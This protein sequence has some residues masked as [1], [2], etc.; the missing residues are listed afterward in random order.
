[1][2]FWKRFGALGTDFASKYQNNPFFRTETRIVAFHV[3]FA[4]FI[5]SALVA[6][7]INTS[8]FIGTTPT[9]STTTD[10]NA[11]VTTLIAAS[12]EQLEYRRIRNLTLVISAIVLATLI[13]S[14]VL[15]QISLKPAREALA[16]QKIFVS[17]IAHELRTPLSTIQT[18]T[19]VALFDTSLN[20]ALRETLENNVRDLK[21]ISEI[22]NNLL[23]L[24]V[25]LQ[26]ERI[27]FGKI[28]LAL[29]VHTALERL[30]SLSVTKQ[31]RLNAP[32]RGNFI[33]WGNGNALE[34]IVTNILK[35]ALTHTPSGGRV[36]IRLGRAEPAMVEL[37]IE[38]TG[39]GIAPADLAHI[40]EPFFRSDRSRSRARG[41]AGLGLTIVHELVKLHRGSIRVHSVLKQGTT[42]LVRIPTGA[43]QSDHTYP[44]SPLSNEI[45]VDYSEERG[46]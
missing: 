38:D 15:A 41:E 34:Q 28:D 36:T 25:S 8:Y 30:N 45:T 33:V 35:N 17:N 23:S 11:V 26:R 2:N 31:V 21:R 32:A 14:Y 37:C 9:M 22:I 29:I 6:S 46:V 42:V 5:V 44:T 27:P 43:P 7:Y 1:M 18:N 13:A 12:F 19:E 3:L 40:F 16:Q 4:A 10:P 20:P 39:A 24:D